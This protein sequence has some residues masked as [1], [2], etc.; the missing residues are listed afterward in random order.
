[1]A[2]FI[3]ISIG[4]SVEVKPLTV[5]KN[6]VY[7]AK[8]GGVLEYGKEVKFK[9]VITEADFEAYAA[10]ATPVDVDANFGYAV[11]A[12]AMVSGGGINLTRI[13]TQDPSITIWMLAEETADGFGYAINASLLDATIPDNCW[14]ASQSGTPIDTPTVTLADHDSLSADLAT[15]SVFFDLEKVDA[16]CP[17]TVDVAANVAPLTATANGVYEPAEGTDG[18]STVTVN[19]PSKP[20][21]TKS[22]TITANGTTDVLPDDGYTMS[23]VTAKVNIPTQ[24]KSV[25]IT[26]NG[27]TAVEP[28]S[29]KMLS[30]V[31]ITTNVPRI[32]M[33]GTT[34]SG[35][36]SDTA[37]FV[38]DHNDLRIFGSGDINTALYTSCGDN[39]ADVTKIY[40]DERITAFGASKSFAGFNNVEEVYM[41]SI[42]K[43]CAIDAYDEQANPYWNAASL[44]FG[45][46]PVGESVTIPEGVTKIGKNFLNMTSGSKKPITAGT[47][48][49]VIPDSVISIGSNAFACNKYITVR[50]GSGLKTVSSGAFYNMSSAARSVYVPDISSW[51]NVQFSGS[52]RASVLANGISGSTN[53]YIGDVLVTDLVIPDTVPE[54]RNLNDTKSITSVTAG[55]STTSVA[56]EAF[57]QSTGLISVTLPA[58]SAIPYEAFMNC[59]VLTKVDLGSATSIADEAFLGCKSLTALILR[60]NSVCAVNGNNALLGCSHLEGSFDATYNPESLKDGYIYVPKSLIDSYKVATNWSTYADQFRAIEDYPEICGTTS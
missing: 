55:N 24:T 28:D 41:P 42:D 18:Y 47:T 39:R 9:D 53:L 49:L 32:N 5:K 14:V 8:T 25:T 1:M 10:N 35:D 36:L 26:E 34:K 13:Q 60:S 15:T 6:G 3:K 44:C 43:A 27:T 50:I 46:S 58:V 17:V 40:V 56:R 16:Y 30:K 59:K 29:G 38:L 21:Q 48:E 22:V 19:V 4:P 7:E 37:S 23:K 57:I 11:Y 51:C 31:D 33:N 54:I 52:G 20:E 45:G 12:V 2:K